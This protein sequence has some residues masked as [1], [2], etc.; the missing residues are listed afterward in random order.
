MNVHIYIYIQGPGEATI[1]LRDCDLSARFSSVMFPAQFQQPIIFVVRY[2][3]AAMLALMKSQLAGF[4]VVRWLP[5]WRDSTTNISLCSRKPSFRKS[6]QSLTLSPR[7][8][9]NHSMVLFLLST[10]ALSTSEPL[11]CRRLFSTF[12]VNSDFFFT[13]KINFGNGRFGKSHTRP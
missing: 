1:L 13:Q 9:H 7:W 5:G 10:R 2:Q 6:K 8:N 3:Y 4:D 11:T 12:N